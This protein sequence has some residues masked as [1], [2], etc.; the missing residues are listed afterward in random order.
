M[1]KAKRAIPEGFSSVTPVLTVDGASRALDWYKRALGAEVLSSNPGSDGKIL[2]AEIRIGTSQLMLH[3]PMMGSKSAR[4]LGGTP[5]ALW[6]YV[7]DCD[8]L[9]DRATAA[10]GG[11]S[12]PMEDQFWGDRC[13]SIT[14]P[15]GLSWTIATRKEDLTRAEL[16]DRQV[17]FFDQMA[18]KSS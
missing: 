6:I 4:E 9:F 1:A 14:D 5:I 17:A 15:F 10:G 13:G 7:E 16:E 18:A 8:A 2:H 12:M 11:V 3:D